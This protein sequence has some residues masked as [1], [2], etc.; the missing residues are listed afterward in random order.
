MREAQVQTG[1]ERRGG[2]QNSCHRVGSIS[3]RSEEG[4]PGERDTGAGGRRPRGPARPSAFSEKWRGCGLD[5]G[6]A[7]P[8]NSKYRGAWKRV[9]GSRNPL[10]F[11]SL[12]FIHPDPDIQSEHVLNLAFRKS[13][14]G[15]SLFSAA[16]FTWLPRTGLDW[17]FR[18]TSCLRMNCGSSLL[19][20][21][22]LT[23]TS[24]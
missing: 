19:E 16:P 21:G 1:E 23:S 9:V 7:G 8:S 6:E 13:S 12:T 4:Q 20:S 24:A 2:G 5:T 17:H 22:S 15:V 10:F 14:L 3:G 18:R 11:P